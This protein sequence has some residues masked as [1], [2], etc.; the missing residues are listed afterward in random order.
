MPAQTLDVE[1]IA[2]DGEGGSRIASEGRTDRLIPRA[3][4]RVPPG[5]EIEEEVALPPELLAAETRHGLEGITRADDGTL[6]RVLPREWGDDAPDTA[7]ILRPTP[8]GKRDAASPAETGWVGLSD[9]AVSDGSPLVLERDDPI[10]EAARVRRITRAPLDGL[11]LAPP[12]TALPVAAVEEV[13]DLVPELRATGGYVLDEV[14]GPAIDADGRAYA[15]ADN[16]GTDDS[17]GE[18]MFL[19]LGAPWGRSGGL[20]GA[21]LPAL[22]RPPRARRRPSG[23][24]PRPRLGTRWRTAP[25]RP[26]RPAPGSAPRPPAP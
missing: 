17:S 4:L 20:G 3:I 26:R 22:S 5:G 7:E 15:A 12:G 6:C 8:E 1:G 13:R 16:D 19:R 25:P 14:E 21:S 10:G 9:L 24:A 11:E 23:R 2:P 18:T